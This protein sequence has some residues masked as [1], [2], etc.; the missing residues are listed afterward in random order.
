V[1]VIEMATVRFSDELKHRIKRNAHAIYTKKL[2]KLKEDFV[3]SRN[4]GEE[5]YQLTFSNTLDSQPDWYFEKREICT[6][7]GF[8]NL[9]ENMSKEQK[10]LYDDLDF[11]YKYPTQHA[12][13]YDCKGDKFKDDNKCRLSGYGTWTL[14]Y[15]SSKWDS[16]KKDVM[17]YTQQRSQIWAERD[18]FVD[19]VMAVVD[20]HATLAP[21]VKAWSGLWELVPEEYQERAKKVVPKADRRV[22]TRDKAEVDL[23]KLTG[24]VVASKLTK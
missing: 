19:G 8:Y 7:E 21:A 22:V 6:F 17:V 14:D 23:N 24:V 9:P 15:E 18:E 3:S 12:V 5:L 11:G 10:Y 4:F 1:E 20:A 13:P 2:D 16:I